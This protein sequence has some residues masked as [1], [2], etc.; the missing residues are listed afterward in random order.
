M[1]RQSDPVLEGGQL[2]TTP[3]VD[4]RGLP[5]GGPTRSRQPALSAAADRFPGSPPRAAG[6][7]PRARSSATHRLARGRRRGRWIPRRHDADGRRRPDGRVRPRPG[8]GRLRGPARRPDRRPPP[9]RGADAGGG[10]VAPSSPGRRGRLGRRVRSTRRPDPGSRAR[11]ARPRTRV[12]SGSTVDPTAR[13]RPFVAAAVI[14]FAAPGQRRPRSTARQLGSS[15]FL[16]VA[17][18]NAISQGEGVTVAVIDTGVDATHPD[19]TGT[20]SRA[21]TPTASVG[22]RDHGL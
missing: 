16:H 2:P 1:G 6:R 13:R 22:R 20:S 3:V 19:L 18:A 9:G 14:L 8:Q 21:S 5:G 17:E 4:S 15:A 7:S 11:P 10:R 12:S